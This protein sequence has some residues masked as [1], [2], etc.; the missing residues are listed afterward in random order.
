VVAPQGLNG[1]VR[2][3][4]DS[5]FPERFLQPGERWIR[6]G[7]RDLPTS[8]SLVRGRYLETK[9]LYVLKFRGVDSRQAAEA[10]R[11]HQLVVDAS[12]RPQLTDGEFYIMDLVEVSVYHHHSQAHLGTVKTVASAGNDLLEIEL[13][14]AEKTRVLVP[15][16]AEFFPRV[17]LDQGRIELAPVKGLLPPEFS[18]D[19]ASLDP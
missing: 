3:Y 5:D 19:V 1:E 2:V 14:D 4:P 11:G 6:K 7:D 8:I 17:D 15:F 18:V 9:N 16:V 10:L 13:V 12:D